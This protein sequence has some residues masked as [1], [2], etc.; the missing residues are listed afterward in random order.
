M[1]DV[2]R[3][4]SS[5]DERNYSDQNPAAQMTGP[6]DGSAASKVTAGVKTPVSA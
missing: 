3:L 6:V 2:N 5:L 1:K 4:L